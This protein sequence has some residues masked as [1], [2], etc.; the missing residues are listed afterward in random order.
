MNDSFTKNLQDNYRTP[1]LFLVFNRVETTKQVF[2]AIRKVKPSKL[3]IASDGPRPDREGEVESVLSIRDYLIN[4]V[5]WECDIKSLFQDKNLGCKNAIN[6]AIQW[7]FQFEEMGVIL[8]DDTLPV[9][10]FFPFIKHYL[11]LYRNNKKVAAIAGRNEIG[12]WNVNNQNHFFS[13]KFFCWGWG[14]WKDRVQDLD[15]EFGYKKVNIQNIAIEGGMK[16]YLVL[17]GMNQS[18]ISNKVNSWAWAYEFN[19]R[20]RKQLTLIPSKNYV[21]NIGFGEDGTHTKHQEED[22][23]KTNVN[24]TILDF[25]GKEVKPNKKY[26]LAFI[27]KKHGNSIIG[28]TRLILKAFPKLNILLNP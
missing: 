17:K 23:V 6:E 25:E 8:E 16:E 5:D 21:K 14:T 10:E 24:E 3:Y 28:W 22:S 12:E 19:F 15:V 2:E 7:F 26:Y 18:M 13:S 11:E 9:P 20:Y 27:N 1:I 4:S